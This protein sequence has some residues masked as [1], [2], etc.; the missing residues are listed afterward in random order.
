M[1]RPRQCGFLRSDPPR[2]APDHLVGAASSLPRAPTVTYGST[3]P[4]R[5][6]LSGSRTE[7]SFRVFDQLT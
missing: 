5:R 6:L 7:E 1:E 3:G 4:E 2:N